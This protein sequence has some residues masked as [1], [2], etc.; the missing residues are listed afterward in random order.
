MR[1]TRTVSIFLTAAALLIFTACSNDSA[2]P[3]SSF[4]TGTGTGYLRRSDT[5]W[6]L[7]LEGSYTDMGRQY[8]ALLKDELQ[9]LYAQVN[10]AVGFGQPTT[11][12]ILSL[13]KANRDPREIQILDGMA[14]ET[15]LSPDQHEFLNASLFFIY[16]NLGCSACSATGSQ[17]ES[18][19][20]IAGRNF[21]NPR[22]VFSSI[23]KGKSV[24][25]IYNPRDQFTGAPPHRDNSV[26]AMTQIGWIYGLTNLNS[27]GIYLEYNNATNS[28]PI[29]PL[30]MHDPANPDKLIYILSHIEDGLHQN[31]YAAF[32]SDTLEEVDARL[33]GKA[34]IAT[35]TQVA[36]KNRVWHYERSPY[37]VAKKIL[38]GGARGSHSYDNPPDMDIFT[39]HFFIDTWLH[40]NLDLYTRFETGG[41]DSGSRTFARLTN[42]QKLARQSA[43]RITAETMKTI[44]TTP[45]RNDGTGGPFIGWELTNPDVT[46]FTSVTDIAGRVMHIYPNVDAHPSF[47]DYRAQ[48]AA[49]DL[50]RE[51]R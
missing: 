44:M 38:A 19:F 37:E 7:N 24:L 36:D 28:I 47:D 2:A 33:S 40:Q 32:D 48:W 26:A 16:A 17:T 10:S 13:L 49:I 9:T 31:L 39:N 20:T 45:L 51:F 42:L 8:G 6:I 23:L 25:V 1:A 21:D 15:G 29:P 12:F 43:G 4:S 11:Q 41:I 5:L 30:D 18:G 35:I 14:R 22:G 27:K 34:A 50:K 46:H 3:S